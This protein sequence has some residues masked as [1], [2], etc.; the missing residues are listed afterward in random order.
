MAS[1]IIQEAGSDY[2]VTVKV[3][4]PSGNVTGVKGEQGI[5]GE[6]GEQGIPGI[7]GPKGDPFLYAD[8]TTE[9]LTSLK[10]VKGDKGDRG[11]LGLQ[12]PTGPVG[13]KGFTGDTGAIGPKGDKGDKGLT[14]ETGS[15]LNVIGSL[16][17]ASELPPTGD[18]GDA[19]LINGN[20]HVWPPSATAFVAIGSIKGDKGDKG[21]I[22]PQG[23]Q[24]LKGDTGETGPSVVVA[25]TLGQSTTDAVSQKLLTDTVGD[26]A[27]I[28]DDINGEV[29]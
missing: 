17:N 10:G 6:R 27:T 15:G 21:D 26:I 22:G 20:L 8:F 4:I 2:K 3:G 28:L 29:I 7:Q 24:G 19:Y 23:L 14:G 16:A 13:P 11:E 9:Q 1:T 25:Q 12:G 5:Q 18:V